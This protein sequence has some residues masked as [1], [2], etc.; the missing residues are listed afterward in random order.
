MVSFRTY[1]LE[2]EKNSHMTHLSDLVFIEGVEGTRKAIDFLRDL[3]HMFSHSN[4]NTYTVKFDGAPAVFVGIDPTDGEF[5]V[6]KKGIFNKTPLIYKTQEDI[7]RDLSGE[8]AKK[9]STLLKYLPNLGI[10]SGIYQGD[11]MYSKE[12]LMTKEIDGQEMIV[13]HPNTIAYA[14][15][16]DSE[17]GRKIAASELGIVFHTTYTGNSFETLKAS[18]GKSITD[19]FR[20]TKQVWAIDATLPNKTKEFTLNDEE[21]LKSELLLKDIGLQFQRMDAKMLNH[22]Y[23]D[24][25]LKALV[26]I[27]VNSLV[28]QNLKNLAPREMSEKFYQF[29]HDRYQK[30]I[31]SKKLEKSKKALTDKKS[32]VLQYFN[33]YD[34]TH[35]AGI[36]ELA[37]SIDL[38]KDLL[39][40]KM[41]RVAGLS[42]F[43][44]TA[45]GF[46]VTNPEGFVAIDSETGAAIKLVD[47]FEF[48]A[49]NFSPEFLKGWA[50]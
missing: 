50:K 23:Q 17:L 8:L 10:R 5:F 3:R 26:L 42:H 9:F 45:N 33:S 46:K 41:K 16:K 37:K 32:R 25:E 2:A 36:F 30:E 4:K 22:I 49:A 14:V 19:K 34:H 29:I 44:K 1:L 31:D 48:S 43:L 12:D 13:F 20:E 15:P 7:D 35:I 28:R 38:L 40:T 39:L 24:E 21:Y 6:A 11:L 18:F 47:R 27:F